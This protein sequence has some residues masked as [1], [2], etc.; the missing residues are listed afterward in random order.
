MLGFAVNH[1][2][3]T[4]WL[5]SHAVVCAYSRQQPVVE[6]TVGTYE[7]ESDEVGNLRYSNRFVILPTRSRSPHSKIFQTVVHYM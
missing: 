2:N 7:N 5:A 3:G 1:H 4:C 6:Y